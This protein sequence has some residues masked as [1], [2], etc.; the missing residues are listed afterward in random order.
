MEIEAAGKAAFK[1][2]QAV[3]TAARKAI[4]CS[5][6]QCIRTF[7]AEEIHAWTDKGETALCPFCDIDAVIAEPVPRA[8]LA[9]MNER[10]F[11]GLAK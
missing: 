7:P 10:W 9:A 4:V 5:C 3:Q 1:N 2:R 11:T 8:M 6:Y